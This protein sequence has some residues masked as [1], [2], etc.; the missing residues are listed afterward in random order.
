MEG[1]YSRAWLGA[2]TDCERRL[3]QL[4]PTTPEEQARND[5]DPD[6][7]NA[8]NECSMSSAAILPRFTEESGNKIHGDSFS[9][10]ILEVSTDERHQ[11]DRSC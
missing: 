6:Q 11:R 3:R 4:V 9:D 1:E 2:E 10:V 7:Q 8:R 5:S